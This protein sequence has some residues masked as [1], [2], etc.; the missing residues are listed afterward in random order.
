VRDG[1]RQF[2]G[3]RRP[4]APIVGL[5]AGPTADVQRVDDRPERRQLRAD[6]EPD[7]SERITLIEFVW[8][9]ATGAQLVIL[10]SREWL[11]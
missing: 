2:G 7:T 8:S 4:I 3:R 1:T 6:V 9:G 10:V 5:V 11:Q